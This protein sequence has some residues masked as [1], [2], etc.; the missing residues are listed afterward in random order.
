MYRKLKTL[1]GFY[2]PS[3][4]RLHV[5][6]PVSLSAISEIKD[7]YTES[8]LLHEFVNTR[9]TDPLPPEQCDPLRTPFQKMVIRSLKNGK[10]LTAFDFQT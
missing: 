5:D 7:D 10:E 1:L 9:Q 8:I 2:S 3:F 4:M 6:T